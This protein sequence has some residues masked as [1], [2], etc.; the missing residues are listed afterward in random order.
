MMDIIDWRK[1]ENFCKENF[2]RLIQEVAPQS[3]K[4][5]V[6]QKTIYAYSDKMKK[7]HTYVPHTQKS[8]FNEAKKYKSERKRVHLKEHKRRGPRRKPKKRWTHF[9]AN[10][11]DA[12]IKSI[13]TA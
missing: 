1:N 11:P 4:L 7:R 9:Y 2:W 6:E 8:N 12:E 5:Q 10:I 3:E 13:D